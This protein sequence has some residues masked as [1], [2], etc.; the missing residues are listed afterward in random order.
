[1]ASPLSTGTIDRNHVASLLGRLIVHLHAAPRDGIQRSLVRACD[2]IEEAIE[3]SRAGDRDPAVPAGRELAGLVD[4][5]LTSEPQ[6]ILE[7]MRQIRRVLGRLDAC[8][9]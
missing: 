7:V 8:I 1:M 3:A 5:L 2:A 9:E 6:R 4:L